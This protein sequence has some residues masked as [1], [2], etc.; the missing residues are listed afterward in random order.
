MNACRAAG[1]EPN[2]FGVQQ[3][4]RE[5]CLRG[6][7]A[8]RPRTAFTMRVYGHLLDD[9]LGGADFLDDLAPD[10]APDLRDAEEA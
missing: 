4:T 1:L 5:D 7:R 10:Q 3:F 8:A 9:G 2:A 6:L